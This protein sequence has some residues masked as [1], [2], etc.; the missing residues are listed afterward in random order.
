MNKDF[1]ILFI[2]EPLWSFICNILSSSN[3]K[4]NKV[5]GAP[6]HPNWLAFLRPLSEINNHPRV[7]S[8]INIHLSHLYFSL[9]K[10]IFNHR[11]I[12]CFSFFN[13]GDIF[14]MIN[15][16]S[17]NHQSALKYLKDAEANLC[18]VLIMAG[19]FNIRDS[20]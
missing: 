6:N 9:Q 3:K 1:N 19:D 10:D 8:Y 2:Q 7:I 11:D 17:D 18:N 14:F 20:D 15:I 12:Y 13:N 4:E 5:V 16:Y